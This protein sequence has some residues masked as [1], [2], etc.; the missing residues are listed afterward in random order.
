MSTALSLTQ[1]S[2]SLSLS[3]RVIDCAGNSLSRMLH[4][5]ALRWHRLLHS[6]SN[7]LHRLSPTY[8]HASYVLHRLSPTLHA[9]GA[10]IRV[11]LACPA[12]STVCNDQSSTCWPV[13]HRS[14]PAL[15]PSPQRSRL[16]GVGHVYAGFTGYDFA[17]FGSLAENIGA[18]FFPS[19][20]P[21]GGGG[22]VGNAT[23]STSTAFTTM[24]NS[25][26]AVAHV[27]VDHNLLES[28]AVFGAGFLMRPV[29]AVLFGRI[30]D[31]TGRKRA[32][33]RLQLPT[34]C[35]V[36]ASAH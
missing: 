17:V 20:C 35:R 8:L 1:L 7:V 27:C 9:N 18:A 25:T 5:A 10:S 32:L 36:Y 23:S 2:L 11:V 13:M 15:R 33:V 22:D 28:F 21:S 30:G 12:R 34:A 6:T 26:A 19:D 14:T 24:S 29:G 31:V 16:C 3:S 4:W